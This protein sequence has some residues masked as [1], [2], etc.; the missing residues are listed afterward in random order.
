MSFTPTNYHVRRED[1]NG[2]GIETI[3]LEEYSFSKCFRIG[4]V[5]WNIKY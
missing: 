2:L 5:I 4:S 3:L 1:D